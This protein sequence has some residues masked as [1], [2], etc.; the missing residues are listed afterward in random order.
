MID[1][2]G[3]A[4]RSDRHGSTLS[5]LISFRSTDAQAQA[6]AAVRQIGKVEPDE[7]GAPQRSGEP[8]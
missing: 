1:T 7:L 6:S 5:F 3:A 4:A 8:H 2:I